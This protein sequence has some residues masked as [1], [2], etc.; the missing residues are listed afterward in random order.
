M[1]RFLMRR[2]V[3]IPIALLVTNFLGYSFAFSIAP[4]V[5]SNN[6]YSRGSTNIPPVLPEYW[7]YLQ[8]AMRGDFGQTYT[9]EPVLEAVSRVGIASLGLVGISLT[10][11]ILFGVAL[12][13][14]AVRR[15]RVGVA[16]WL[17]FTS[18]I[19]LALP[20]FYIAILLITFFL[21]FFLYGTSAKTPPIPFQGFG[22]DAHLLLPVLALTFQ[23]TV[24][25][26][27]VTGSLLSEEMEKQYVTAAMSFGHSFR[28]MKDRFAFRA[29][30]API[31]LVIAASLRIM[32]AELV[33]IE[34]LFNWPGLGKLIASSLSLGSRS[35]NLLAPPLVAA[36]LTVLV[37]VF[38]FSDLIATSLS[39]TVDPRLRVNT[40]PEHI[41]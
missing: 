20:S 18:T 32:I 19:G 34:R 24:K 10:L 14:L 6:P 36:L 37:A 23:P 16:T 26:A 7:N 8:G 13:R 2:L 15:N 4:I 21:L 39:R 3:F 9:N 25:I 22:W 40:E 1:L 12:G 17:T 28:R 5:S 27:Q 33:I 35:E 38:M 41:A 31:F 11:S 30:I 29:I